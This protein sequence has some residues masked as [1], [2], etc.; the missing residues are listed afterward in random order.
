VPPVR[1]VILSLEESPDLDSSSVE[2]LHDFYRF[3]ANDGKRLILAR[4]KDPVQ[5]LLQRLASPGF[6]A[7]ALSGLSVDDAVRLAQAAT[8]PE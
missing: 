4:L 8:D 2:A 3:V 7:Q 5:A 1:T 6:P